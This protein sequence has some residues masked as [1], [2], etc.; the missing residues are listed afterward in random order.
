MKISKILRSFIMVCSCFFAKIVFSLFWSSGFSNGSWAILVLNTFRRGFLFET[1]LLCVWSFYW[2]IQVT[3]LWDLVVFAKNRFR[4]FFLLSFFLKIVFELTLA[5]FFSEIMIYSLSILTLEPI[6]L[7]IK[8]RKPGHHKKHHKF[9]SLI[10]LFCLI[11]LFSFLILLCCRHGVH[12]LLETKE[13]IC[14]IVFEVGVK[15]QNLFRV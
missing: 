15:S 1:L 12:H 14:E 10:F 13:V 11:I 7:V 6:S 4:N 9:D 3:L 5:I 2:N 8:L